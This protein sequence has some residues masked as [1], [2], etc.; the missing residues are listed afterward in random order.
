V[1]SRHIAEVGFARRENFGLGDLRVRYG[2]HWSSEFAG[3]RAGIT[4]ESRERR[5]LEV[6][7]ESWNIPILIT[8]AIQGPHCNGWHSLRST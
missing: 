5:R 7:P 8:G 3:Y 4:S 6:W 1:G 2:A